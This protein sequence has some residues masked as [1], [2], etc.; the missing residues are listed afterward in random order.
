MEQTRKAIIAE[1]SKGDVESGFVITTDGI[2]LF[3]KEISLDGWV[4]V[5]KLSAVNG[6]ISNLVNGTTTATKL[7]ATNIDL[8]TGTLRIG[9]AN[10]TSS[11][12]Q[13]HGTYY[14]S[15]TVSMPGVAG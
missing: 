5:D 15:L 4:K 3:G 13:Y 2:K 8:T 6:N 7:S 12:L 14:Y 1:V 9:D 11:K 10:N